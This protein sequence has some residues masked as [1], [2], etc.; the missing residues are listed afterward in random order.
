[1]KKDFWI[2]FASS[3]TLVALALLVVVIGDLLLAAVLL[4]V[5]L[6]A[7]K[8][9]LKSFKLTDTVN[10]R[11]AAVEALGTLAIDIYYL[12][13]ALSGAAGAANGMLLFAMVLLALI[14]YL[15]YYVFAFP[16][17][18]I[19]QIAE[20]FFCF[21]YAPVMLSCIYLTRHLGEYG[22]YVVWLIFLS[23]WVNDAFA[24]CVGISIGKR[25]LAPTLSP[26]KTWEGAIG[27]VAGAMLCTILYCEIFVRWLAPELDVL[28]WFTIISGVGAV[29]SQVGD[30]AASAIKRNHDI[31]D[32]G[33][34]IP[35]HGGIVDR[36]DSVIFIAPVIYVLAVVLL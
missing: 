3:T 34:L 7:Y 33:S 27:G 6:V 29:I 23:S 22:P 9:L 11:P 19:T 31:K 25:K 2:R 21:L 28:L 15:T 12:V 26:K 16:K 18:G 14:A 1:M 13:L 4:L 5:S 32:F 20:A 8:E 30:L 35:G 10:K 36:F 24:Y 17:C